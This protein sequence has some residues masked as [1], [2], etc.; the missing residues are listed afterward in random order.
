[1][2]VITFAKRKKKCINYGPSL[3]FTSKI[4]LI[5]EM[6]KFFLLLL[7]S[8]NSIHLFFSLLLV[9]FIKHKEIM[10]IV[11]RICFGK[12]LPAKHGARR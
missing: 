7:S 12:V 2:N 5:Y 3:Q 8:T 4:A 11:G 1:M 9:T 6:E 10:L